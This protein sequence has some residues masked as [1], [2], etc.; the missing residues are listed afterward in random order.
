MARSRWSLDSAKIST[1]FQASCTALLICSA[2]G[3]ARPT[4][5][6]TFFVKTL[7]DVTLA[8]NS[9]DYYEADTKPSWEL[10]RLLRKGVTDF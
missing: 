1:I 8:G 5:A 7:D 4:I 2:V 9:E 3:A 10:K 6:C